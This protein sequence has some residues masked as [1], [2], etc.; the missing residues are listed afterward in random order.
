ML[1]SQMWYHF[2]EK[3]Q[4]CHN[5]TRGTRYTPQ[6]YKNFRTSTGFPL[7]WLGVSSLLSVRA[8]GDSVSIR[9][10]HI[11]ERNVC[12]YVGLTR[13]ACNAWQHIYFSHVYEWLYN[14]S[15]NIYKFGKKG[16]W[17]CL[18]I[19]FHAKNVWDPHDTQALFYLY[20][21]LEI[22]RSVAH[23]TALS[24]AIVGVSALI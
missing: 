17:L 14:Y 15:T 4:F 2:V 20:L 5:I 16:C 6:D 8:G 23:V 10:I 3:L 21:M 11:L 22:R 12:A 19:L 9:Y 7:S 13:H 18:K 24:L 1:N